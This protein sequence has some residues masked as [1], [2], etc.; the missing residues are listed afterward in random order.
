[1]DSPRGDQVDL[2][3]S[4]QAAD[5]AAGE[6]ASPRAETG[7]PPQVEASCSWRTDEFH[8][9]ECD[10]YYDCPAHTILRAPPADEG[11]SQN[12]GQEEGE[13]TGEA[14][15]PATAAVSDDDPYD[16]PGA[17]NNTEPQAQAPTL[18]NT[19]GNGEQSSAGGRRPESP[20]EDRAG[21]LA[22]DDDAE[23]DDS[24]ST[25][26]R[27][28]PTRTTSL[29]AQ[30]L[31]RGFVIARDPT[32]TD[33]PS[34]QEQGDGGAFA[35][36]DAGMEASAATA[37]SAHTRRSSSARNDLGRRSS[38]YGGGAANFAAR[39]RQRRE[40]PEYSVP[41]WQPDAEVTYCPICNAQFSIFIRKHHCR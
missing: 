34:A 35:T 12:P 27:S 31:Q 25:S 9:G 16:S 32:E 29:R 36:E 38:L 7:T 5:S 15:L 24:A 4:E 20:L 3:A 28:F 23:S 39:E 6:S 33:E 19:A 11:A 21:Q 10:R 14:A 2:A 37:S 1:M 18:E 8:D 22:I 40:T 26:S 41:R 13:E 17:E 30:L